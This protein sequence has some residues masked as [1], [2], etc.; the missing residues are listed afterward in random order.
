MNALNWVY[1]AVHGWTT[2]TNQDVVKDVVKALSKGYYPLMDGNKRDLLIQK[3]IFEMQE[4]YKKSC[5]PEIIKNS[6]KSAVM[7][8]LTG[9][10]NALPELK[11]A[12]RAHYM[13]DPKLHEKQLEVTDH[14]YEQM[15]R[16]MVRLVDIWC[17]MI[18]RQF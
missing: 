15:K 10:I 18:A 13:H 14:K 5:S 4:K 17:A 7:S 3:I 9:Q 6:I 1:G 16:E 8:F 2:Q 11:A 12:E